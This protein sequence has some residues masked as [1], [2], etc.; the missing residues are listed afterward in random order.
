MIMQARF[1]PALQC[2]FLFPFFIYFFLSWRLAWETIAIWK[3]A[4][5]P[6]WPHCPAETERVSRI[7]NAMQMIF[8][9]PILFVR[10]L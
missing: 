3:N 9:F 5:E 4:L 7:I 8:D 10:K 1:D 2:I 6:Q